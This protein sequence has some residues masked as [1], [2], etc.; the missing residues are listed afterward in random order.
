MI[1]LDFGSGLALGLGLL[2]A[3]H[4]DQRRRSQLLLRVLRQEVPP[5]RLGLTSPFLGTLLHTQEAQQILTTAL[6][7][8]NY[9]LQQMPLAYVQVDGDNL[10]QGCNQA[11]R[12]LLNL[13]EQPSPRPRLLLELF[14]SYDLDQLIEETRQSQAPC[15]RE[16]S[17]NVVAMDP[18]NPIPQP[19]LHLRGYGFPL[20]DGKVGVFL[21]DRQEVVQ[22]TQQRNRWVSDVAHELRTP[23]T[24][25]RLVA[26]TLVSRVDVQWKSWMERLLGETIHLSDLVQNLLDLSRLDRRS[27]PGLV[28]TTVDLVELIDMAWDTLEP[29]SRRHHIQFHYDGPEQML[30]EA[31]RSHLYRVLLNLLDNA[32]KYSPPQSAI[33]VKLSTSLNPT[34]T[35]RTLPQD[36]QPTD[37]TTLCLEVIDRGTGFLAEDLPHVFERFYRSDPSRS[38]QPYGVSS[39]GLPG[40]TADPPLIH[41]NSCGLG[42][43]IVQQIIQAHQGSVTAQNHPS[44]GGAWLKIHLPVST[45]QG[46]ATPNPSQT[47]PKPPFSA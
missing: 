16:W 43:A 17:I 45:P 12:I 5:R 24:S 46:T 42:L 15:Q 19:S 7:D 18:V 36:S 47:L 38:R 34:E 30:L 21:D 20:N 1:G 27:A 8:L 22:L 31:D 33:T 2:L 25:I 10:F 32:L 44:L 23:L 28:L 26:E 39:P 29:L 9:L 40:E 13:P 37:V 11:A 6:G 3:Y 4:L 35:S 14:R 41:S